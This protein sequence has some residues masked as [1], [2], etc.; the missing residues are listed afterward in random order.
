M[1]RF[2]LFAALTLSI[3][4][5]WESR[6]RRLGDAEFD[7]YYALKPFMK[8]EERKAYLTLKTE[9][10]RDAW[11]KANG[12]REVLGSK[13]CY[14]ERFFKYDEKQRQA[15]VEGDVAVG[16]TREMVFMS[17]GA[18]FD[19]RA[20]AGRPAQL[21]E[22]FIYKFEKHEDGSVLVYVPGSKTEYKAVDRFRREVILDD[23]VVAS[24]KQKA[25]WA[26]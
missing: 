1:F 10:E 8:D 7:R 12:C 24:I 20:V 11:L 3:A 2:A 13:E 5:S 14:W 17:W 19:R 16:W 26:N 22:M 21:S 15:I 9:E 6:V 25:G 18:P 23:D 4:C